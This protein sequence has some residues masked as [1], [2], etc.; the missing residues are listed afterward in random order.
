M[1]YATLRKTHQNDK[2]PEQGGCYTSYTT[3]PTCYCTQGKL[4]DSAAGLHAGW[5]TIFATCCKSRLSTAA[6]KC[7]KCLVT[8]CHAVTTTEATWKTN[9]TYWSTKCHKHTVT[10]TPWHQAT[11]P[12]NSY[13]CAWID[14]DTTTLTACPPPSTQKPVY[15][16]STH[17]RVYNAQSLKPRWPSHPMQPLETL[18]RAGSQAASQHIL[19]PARRA[20]HLNTLQAQG[21]GTH[22][23]GTT[24]ASREDATPCHA[25]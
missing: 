24:Q 15:A 18:P 4:Q 5:P 22:A 3:Y 10:S 12:S 25:K 19:Q 17:K 7:A 2:L 6:R 14:Q 13:H 21:P 20:T 1:Y 23:V 9:A 11:P 8:P 16:P